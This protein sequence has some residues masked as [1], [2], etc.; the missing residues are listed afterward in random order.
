MLLALLCTVY[1]PQDSVYN[2]FFGRCCIFGTVIY[3]NA[4]I[5]V[6]SAKCSA[7]LTKRFSKFYCDIISV[8]TDGRRIDKLISYRQFLRCNIDLVYLDFISRCAKYGSNAGNRFIQGFFRILVVAQTV[9]SRYKKSIAISFFGCGWPQQFLEEQQHLFISITPL[10]AIC[11]FSADAVFF[12]GCD[13]TK[14]LLRFIDSILIQRVVRPFT[15]LST[16]DNSAFT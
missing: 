14:K 4:A 12:F 9:V 3:P 7:V 2:Q 10:T 11:F 16:F 6:I 1:F 8:H 5:N 13:S 15:F